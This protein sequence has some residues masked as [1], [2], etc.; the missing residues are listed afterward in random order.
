MQT[1]MFRKL[2]DGSRF[3]LYP[4]MAMNLCLE[5]KQLKAT[6][7]IQLFYLCEELFRSG[8]VKYLM[9]QITPTSTS[10]GPIY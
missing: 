1:L 4:H 6:I 2:L 7:I 3:I 10:L 8:T 9:V 5:V